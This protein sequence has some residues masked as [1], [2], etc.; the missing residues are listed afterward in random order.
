MFSLNSL[1]WIRISNLHLWYNYFTNFTNRYRFS[2]TGTIL[3]NILNVL[4]WIPGDF[5]DRL[6][7][8]WHR[9]WSRKYLVHRMVGMRIFF[10]SFYSFWYKIERKLFLGV[11]EVAEHEY[12]IGFG[13]GN[14]WC[15]GWWVCE[16]PI[17]KK[18][19][20]NPAKNSA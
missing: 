10:E 14:T 13:P 7:R 18:S 11:F 4:S 8:I 1:R 20:E 16:S 5:W 2:D 15:P 3:V 6:I 19:A 9:L 12:D 17:R